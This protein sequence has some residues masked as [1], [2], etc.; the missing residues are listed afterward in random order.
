M[1]NKR[2]SKK[3]AIDGIIDEIY[4][5]FRTLVKK[6]KKDAHSIENTFKKIIKK[7]W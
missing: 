1:T 6:K 7:K 4:I 3:N 5:R 2:I